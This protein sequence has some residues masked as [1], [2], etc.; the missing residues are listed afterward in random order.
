MKDVELLYELNDFVKLVMKI[1]KKMEYT[2]FICN[3]YNDLRDKTINRK[4]I[5]RFVTIFVF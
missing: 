5:F 3:S 1:Y 4:N 2:K